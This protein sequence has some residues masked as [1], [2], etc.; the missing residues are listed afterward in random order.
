MRQKVEGRTF[1]EERALYALRDADVTDC[2]FD[3]P[4]DGESALKE[5][6]DIRVRG[7]R[8]AL[9]YPI[10]HVRGLEMSGS[11]MAETTRAALWYCD[12]VVIDSCELGGIKAL[13]ECNDFSIS[14]C[15]IDSAEFGWKCSRIGISDSE[16]YSE[17]IFLDSHDISLDNVTMRGKYS[18][19]YTDGLTIKDS[20]LDTKDAFWH[21]RNAVVRDSVVK[22]EYLGWYSENLAL[23]NCEIIGT[24]PLCY[25][26]GLRLIG[27]TMRDCD[28]SFE[29]SEVD[30]DIRG[31]IDS[32][33]NPLS[34]RIV[35][36]SY[37]D[38]ITDGAVRDCSC[39]IVRRGA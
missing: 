32:V 38:I 9:R 5:S 24:Q 8:F 20:R 36:D 12:N 13:R 30:A 25:C 29:Y 11:S 1:D 28:L 27:C 26:K 19:Q 23:I 14:G 33:K 18:F 4:A 39:E 15:R 10:W 21:S 35:A 17:Y 34:G 16:I 6:S 2:V 7:C 31:G 37:G 3:G 22:G